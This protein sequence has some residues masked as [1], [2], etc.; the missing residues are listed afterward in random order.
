MAWALAFVAQDDLGADF[1]ANRCRS[2]SYVAF[3]IQF[4]VPEGTQRAGHHI[5]ADATLRTTLSCLLRLKAYGTYH[6]GAAFR[7]GR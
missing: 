7:V 5:N 2:V 1:R 6:A 4:S 3:E